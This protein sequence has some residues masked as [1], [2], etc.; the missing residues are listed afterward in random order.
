MDTLIYQPKNS[1][2]RQSYDAKEIEEPLNGDGFGIG[3]YLPE[4]S[5]EPS[6]FVS[7]FPAWS[8]RNLR[9]L[10]PRIK[11]PCLFAHVRAASFG[12]TSEANCHPFQYQSFLMMHNGSIEGFHEIKREL[13]RRLSDDIYNWVK[14]QT[15]SEHFFAMFL[16]KVRHRSAAPGAQDLAAALH[17]TIQEVETMKAEHGIKEP[18][19]LNTVISD[20]KS[21]VGTRFISGTDEDPLTL[22]WSEGAKYVCD[23][24]VCH[25]VPAD[26]EEQTVLI[27]SEKLTG[28][29]EDWRKVPANHMVVVDHDNHV[30]LQPIIVNARQTKVS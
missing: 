8:N 21:M 10:A 16:D 3:W 25:M 13:R 6:V 9:S 20:G 7:V 23:G 19:Y 27:V 28:L 30:T 11:S 2:I 26:R 29:A 24:E 15:D 4:L 22:Y 14:G 12:D 17:A 5:A 18:T 1:L